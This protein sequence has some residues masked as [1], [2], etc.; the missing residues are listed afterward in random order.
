MNQFALRLLAVV[1]GLA[2]FFAAPASAETASKA[3]ANEKQMES[4]GAAQTTAQGLAADGQD[5]IE[6]SLLTCAP[7]REAYSFYGHTAL[8]VHNLK[9]GN[10]WVFNY[11]TFDFNTDHFVWRFMM[12]QTD[13]TL[14]VATFPAFIAAYAHDHRS[15][16]EQ[17]LNLRNDEALRLTAG[18]ISIVRQDGWTYRYNFLYDNCT[19]R[20]LSDVDHCLDGHIVWAPDTALCTF[21]G[22]IREF[23][24]AQ[25]PWN[26]FGQDLILGAETDVPLSVEQQLFSP[27][28]A[29]HHAMRAVIADGSGRERP[30]VR[31]SRLVV[32]AQTV[33]ASN[34]ILTPTVACILAW[35]LVVGLML[36]ERKRR[37]AVRLFDNFVLLFW[38]LLGALVALLFFFSEHPAVG[39][40]WNVLLLNPVP[41]VALV[42]K[43]WTDRRGGSRWFPVALTVLALI[44]LAATLF[45]PQRIPGE[46]I[47]LAVLAAVRGLFLL[48]CVENRTGR[49]SKRILTDIR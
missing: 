34:A 1:I 43:L 20:A 9:N 10:D 4:E 5:S 40:N 31:T 17:V 32:P 13:Y 41:L 28:Y 44:F 30:L 39:S 16:T 46:L 48:F 12:G 27:I 11:G 45:A 25:S 36:F 37:T 22:I 19:T 24:D 42:A 49:N 26:A 8:R 18:L 21:R 3:E 38:G 14:G 23:A 2:A 33:D 35:V 6:I 29:M 7:G 47:A 15:V